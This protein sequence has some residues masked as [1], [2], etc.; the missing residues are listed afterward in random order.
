LPYDFNLTINAIVERKI[1]KDEAKTPNRNWGE[2]LV[3]NEIQTLMFDLRVADVWKYLT[4]VHEQTE[5][6]NQIVVESLRRLP[7]TA[8]KETIIT[9]T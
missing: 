9:T 6:G 8:Q 2:H 1:P 4:N 7:T 3:A 5:I